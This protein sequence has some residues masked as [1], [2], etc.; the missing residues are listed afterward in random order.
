LEVD[1]GGAS[2]SGDNITTISTEETALASQAL[3]S[4]HSFQTSEREAYFDMIE[5][6]FIMTPLQ[7]FRLR[8]LGLC[9]LENSLLGI[10]LAVLQMM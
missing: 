5:T 1:C 8:L 6:T 9:S 10:Y 3:E 4:L 2:Y 7:W